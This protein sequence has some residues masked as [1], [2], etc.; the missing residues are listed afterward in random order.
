MREKGCECGKEMEGLSASAKTV[1]ARMEGKCEYLHAGLTAV[2]SPVEFPEEMNVRGCVACY[3]T[4]HERTPDDG[5]CVVCGA[6]S[7]SCCMHYEH[8]Q[9]KV[10]R[11]VLGSRLTNGQR[12]VRL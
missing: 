2:F 8:L 3:K 10:E 9:N 7:C 5:F 4:H 6:L 11:A 12:F 1:Q